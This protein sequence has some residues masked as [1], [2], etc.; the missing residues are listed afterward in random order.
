VVGDPPV[1]LS[2]GAPVVLGTDV[3]RNVFVFCLLGSEALWI[4]PPGLVDVETGWKG[5]PGSEKDG[6]VAVMGGMDRSDRRH[7]HCDV[8][9]HIQVVPGASVERKVGMMVEKWS[10]AAWALG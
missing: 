5:P 8:L 10:M 2:V 9:C 6:S 1:V 3:G 7:C 4:G